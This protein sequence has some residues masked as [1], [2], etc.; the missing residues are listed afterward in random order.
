MMNLHKEEEDERLKGSILGS[1]LDLRKGKEEV[2]K[3]NWR[4]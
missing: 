2:S 4:T 3:G 1:W